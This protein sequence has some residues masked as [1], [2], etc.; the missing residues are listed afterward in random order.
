MTNNPKEVKDPVSIKQ[1]KMWCQNIEIFETKIKL[2][3]IN[4]MTMEIL[5]N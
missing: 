5:K 3:E 4:I 1:E 2:L